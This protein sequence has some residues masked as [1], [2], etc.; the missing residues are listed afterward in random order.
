MTYEG[1]FE[2]KTILGPFG[3]FLASE[4]LFGHLDIPGPNLEVG[5]QESRNIL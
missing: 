5:A 4:H 2:G 1:A 3:L